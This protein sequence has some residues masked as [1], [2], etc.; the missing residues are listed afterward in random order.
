MKTLSL[1]TTFGFIAVAQIS[2]SAAIV[3][4][5][6][7]GLGTSSVDQFQ[8]TAGGGWL[9]PWVNG[10]PSSTTSISYSVVNTTPLS[11][12]RG[13]YL[14][15][16][17]EVAG[18]GAGQ[19]RNGIYRNYDVASLGAGTATFSWEFRFD[20]QV[21][22][23]DAFNDQIKFMDS[24]T[25]GTSLG[26]SAADN[27]WFMEIR[28][29]AGPN[30]TLRARNGAVN[31]DTSNAISLGVNYAF[32]VI[33]VP[34]TK[35][36]SFTVTRLDTSTVVASGTNFGWYNTTA[37]DHGGFFALIPGIRTDN[38]G[39]K[40]S[41]SLDNVGIVVPEPSTYALLL[42]IGI[43]GLVYLRRRK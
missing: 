1:L 38:V 21:G 39:D 27:T 40:V 25:A 28:G 30:Y 16:T 9:G 22:F 26:G 32:E 31:A 12:G 36:Y 18:V 41:Y 23:S 37:T 3:A 29:G 42:G 19:S 34:S 4:N 20:S 5:F 10:T 24:D 6:T 2:A 13:N 15:G 43:C 17:N 14:I 11:T 7:D 33:S 8:G 35:S